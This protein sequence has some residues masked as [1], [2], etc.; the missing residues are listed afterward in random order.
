MLRF[1]GFV[2]SLKRSFDVI[3]AKPVPA[4][5]GSGNPVF[6]N[7]SGCL[8]SQASRNFRLFTSFS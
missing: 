1:D 2:K 5:A 3:P 8:P 7:G 6:S 4:E